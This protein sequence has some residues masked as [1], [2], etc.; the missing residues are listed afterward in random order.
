MVNT[1]HPSSIGNKSLFVPKISRK[2]G[3][4]LLKLENQADLNSLPLGNWGIREPS[5][6][7]AE[8]PRL[9]GQFEI[10]RFYFSYL[11]VDNKSNGCWL[12]FNTGSWYV[13]DLNFPFVSPTV[14]TGVAFDRSMSRLG[15]GKGYY[16]RYIERYI[17]DG[18]PRPLLVAL[19][20]RDQLLSQA[21]PVEE[22]DFKMDMIITPDEVTRR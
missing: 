1:Q 3:M 7:S 14:I 2:G 22:H 19:G 5:Y 20:L 13:R 8:G 12:G 17:A 4:E 9:N 10:F 18:K 16:D 15:H 6:E 11:I 21:I